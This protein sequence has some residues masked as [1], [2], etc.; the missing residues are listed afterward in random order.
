MVERL[1]S[2]WPRSFF[3][4]FPTLTRFCCCTLDAFLVLTVV[5]LVMTVVMLSPARHPLR[6]LWY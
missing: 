2:L 3:L 6:V 4:L 1:S 5:V